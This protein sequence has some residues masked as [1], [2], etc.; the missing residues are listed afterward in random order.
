MK[1]YINVLC[2]VGLVLG[3]MNVTGQERRQKDADWYNCSFEEDGVY[4]AAVNKAYRFLQGK[5]LKKKPVIAFIGTG[6]DVEH[7]D[8][9]DAIWENPNP[10]RGDVNG[11]NFIGGRDGEMLISVPSVA[12][13]EYAR[14][15]KYGEIF[16]CDGKFW[17]IKDEK[18]VE[19]EGEVNREEFDYYE[20][21]RKTNASEV[22]GK[23]MSLHLAYCMRDYVARADREMREM[24][25]GKQLMR[26]D[27]IAWYT[28]DKRVKLRIDSMCFYF[29]NFNYGMQESYA[30]RPIA[31]DT[32]A[33]YYIQGKYIEYCREG[34]EKAVKRVDLDLRRRVVGDDYLDLS[35]D[36]YGNDNL[37][38]SACLAEV[39]RASIAVGKRGNG[40]GADGIAD[41]AKLMTLCVYPEKGE[42][43]GKDLILSL[44]YAVDHGADIVVLAYQLRLSTPADRQGLLE[45]L[46]YAESKNVLVVIPVW[47]SADDMDEEQYYPNR[48]MGERELSNMVVVGP[49]DREGRP[50]K[51]SNYGRKQVD[52]FA[53]S[54]DIYVATTGDT[55]QV[56]TSSALGAGT[57]A[58]VAALLRGYYP[59]LTARQLRNILI[60]TVTSRKGVE[61]EKSTHANGRIVQDL[62]LFDEL[63]VSGGIVNAYNA[64]VAADR[65]EK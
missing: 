64:V 45:V 11:W 34:Y 25:L 48:F 56:G 14:L 40:L 13:R 33:P 50:S 61:V 23:R 46:Q 39:M 10:E 47:E 65:L 62:F 9:R 1:R 53:P 63:C 37:F 17:T 24:F 5:E 43:Y 2:I 8:L 3:V 52:L 30:K 32:I 36:R 7:E 20:F 58:G 18:V 38:S 15:K 28:K 57:V 41:F 21:L 59:Q 26:E 54:I 6:M 51:M 19:Y 31:W 44:R 42:P 49:S 22:M 16:F 12:D 55:Y 29:S 4:G 35:D 27:Y 60:E